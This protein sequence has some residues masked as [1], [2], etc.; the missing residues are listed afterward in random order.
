MTGHD[1][2]AGIMKPTIIPR[3]KGLTLRFYIFPGGWG[4]VARGIGEGG[5]KINPTG[6]SC[7]YLVDGL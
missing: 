7:W 5:E 2:L 6:M 4:L 1:P 3:K